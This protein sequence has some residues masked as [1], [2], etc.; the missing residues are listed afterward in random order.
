MSAEQSMFAACEQPEL[1]SKAREIAEQL[2]DPGVLAEHSRATEVRKS[3]YRST[4]LLYSVLGIVFGVILTAVGLADQFGGLRLPGIGL[5]SLIGGVL[6]LGVSLVRI[7]MV[8]AASATRITVNDPAELASRLYRSC[9][10]PG[11]DLGGASDR[12]ARMLDVFPPVVSERYDGAGWAALK[13]GKERRGQAA[14]PGACAHCSASAAHCEDTYYST[15][16]GD[17]EEKGAFT[18][19]A[20]CSHCGVVLCRTC[21][22]AAGYLCPKCGAATGGW[23]AL[24]DRWQRCYQEVKLLLAGDAEP[25]SLQLDVQASLTSSEQL[26]D[27]VVHMVAVTVRAGSVPVHLVNA[28]VQT[29]GHCFVVSPEPGRLVSLSPD[30][31]NTIAAALTHRFASTRD[32][33]GRCLATVRDAES[34]QTLEQAIAKEEVGWT[35]A[36][37]Q[38]GLA[39]FGA[40]DSLKM[41]G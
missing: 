39:V 37:M 15:H 8:L 32:V 10:V 4:Q 3:K 22:E 30:A 27:A 12:L 20:R 17:D 40:E 35:K 7:P 21:A 31:T 25:G 36:S 5:L 6:I 28:V 11:S 26:G 16:K 34:R 2:T 19:F 29:G 24:G 41:P 23:D 14:I 9:L 1:L 18:W 33:A 38:A 13:S